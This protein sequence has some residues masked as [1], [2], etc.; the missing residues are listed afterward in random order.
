MSQVIFNSYIDL[1]NIG[2]TPSGFG[3]TVAYDLDGVLKQKD[4]D[5][6]VTPVS[7]RG[8]LESTLALGNYSGTYSIRMGTSSSINTINGTGRVQL[9]F[10][11]TNS[12]NI[13]ATN[14]TE[15]A[16]T[17]TSPKG[18]VLN[19]TWTTRSGTLELS[20]TTFS[21]TVGT[22]TYSTFV[23]STPSAVSIGHYDANVGA[24]GRISVFDSGR[25][26]DGQ[27]SRHKAYV[28]INS[29]GSTTSYGVANS[30]VVGG[31]FLTASRSNYVYLGNWVNVN[32]RYTLPNVDG[33]ANQVMTTNGS[34]TVSWAT[35]SVGAIPLSTVLSVGSYSGP[36]NIVFEDLFGVILGT[37]SSHISNIASNSY[38]SLNHNLEGG[39]LVTSNGVNATQSILSIGTVSTY[40]QAP[41]ALLD[42]GTASVTTLDGQGLK[43][44]ADYN[45]TFV[46]YSLVT[47]GYV[48]TYGGGYDTHLV[49]YVDPNKGSDATG[50]VG[51]PNRPYQSIASAMIGITGSAYSSSNR[52]VIH[53]RKGNYTSVARLEN[54]VDYFCESGVVFTQN[55]FKD[56]SAVTSNVYGNAS[57]IGTNANLVPLSLQYGSVVR[58]SFDV[59]DNSSSFG[60]IYGPATVTITG[61]SIRTKSDSGYGISLESSAIVTI[62]VRDGILA[63]YNSIRFSSYTGTASVEA[64]YVNCNA[65][66]GGSGYASPA[67]IRAVVGSSLASSVSIKADVADVSASYGGSPQAALAVS[68]GNTTVRG[69]VM[70]L[71]GNAIIVSGSLDGK[72][73]VIGD[74]S[75]SREAI[76]NSHTGN[77]QTKIRNSMVKSDGL[78][79]YTQSVY[80]SGPSTTF[81][82]NS[83]IVNGL[84]DSTIIQASDEMSTI[85]MYNCLAYSPGL[86][87]S[88]IY[89]T[90]SDYTIGLHNVR[91]NK[92]NP[93]NITDLFDPSGFIYDPYLFVPLF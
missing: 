77:F 6:V 28:H 26:Y 47:K 16:F 75:G 42:F 25:T 62:R 50:A 69:N 74:V 19:N 78:G 60:R 66:L 23:Q 32:N 57:F 11:G 89:S 4:Q 76:L 55:G 31:Q 7:S 86:G 45:A 27:G 24:D 46:T 70:S 53:L 35:F 38:M 59:V 44:T 61:N 85:A 73:D 51:K 82:D 18:V 52:G 3:Y 9:D 92:D 8:N 80:I 90:A 17:R 41:V 91:S 2:A 88:F 63:A 40:I 56:F 34:G 20:S 43:Y 22:T 49:A 29:F 83:T 68:T 15:S 93:D 87:G 72:L 81:I 65:D 67:L 13:S 54:N 12:V 48:D 36:R 10:G 30:V 37:N 33:L 71:R 64:P 21:A 5:G 79:T 1:K 84:T 14:S 39:F 58:F